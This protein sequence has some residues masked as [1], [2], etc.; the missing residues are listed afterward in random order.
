MKCVIVIMLGDWS[1]GM[2]EGSGIEISY[3][4]RYEGSWKTDMVCCIS[5]ATYLMLRTFYHT[6]HFKPNLPR[7]NMWNVQA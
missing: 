2:R 6:T 1:C 4:T 7:R 3:R 5:S